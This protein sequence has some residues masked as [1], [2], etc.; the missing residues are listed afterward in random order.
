MKKKYP[1]EATGWET[2][3][4]IKYTGTYGTKESKI[5]DGQILRNL[6]DVY[7]FLFNMLNNNI[8]KTELLNVMKQQGKTIMG[9]MYVYS[10]GRPM[11]YIPV[12]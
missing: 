4:N 2:L 8:I 5:N 3:F 9:D 6:T 10:D 11:K 12:K 7:E 1:L